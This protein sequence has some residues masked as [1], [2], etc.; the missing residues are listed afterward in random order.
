MP[1]KTKAK[2]PAPLSAAQRAAE[3]ARFGQ[4]ARG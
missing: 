3:L 4:K 1:A 2:W